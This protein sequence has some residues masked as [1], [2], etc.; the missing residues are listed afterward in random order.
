M[1]EVAARS[2]MRMGW[3]PLL[4]RAVVGATEDEAFAMQNTNR[5]SV[6]GLK[7]LMVVVSLS[8]RRNDVEGEEEARRRFLSG[9]TDGAAAVT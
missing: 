1:Y 6:A 2:K 5:M 9:A 4:L 3:L 7:Q 8:R